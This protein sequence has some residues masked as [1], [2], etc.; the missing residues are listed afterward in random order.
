MTAVRR[1][2]PPEA[3]AWLGDLVD[4]GLIEKVSRLGWGFRNESWKLV[5]SD[6]RRLAVTRHA[7]PEAAAAAAT[8]SSLVRQRVGA[9]GIPTPSVVDLATAPVESLLITEFIEGT[10]GAELLAVNGGSAIV[11]SVLGGTWRR[12]HDVDTA[13]LPLDATWAVG[14][15]LVAASVAR[16]RR[17]GPLLAGSERRQL[18]AAID[19]AGGWLSGRRA[20]FAHGDLA[21]VNVVIRGGTLAALLDLEFVRLA[22]PLLDAAWFDWI[23]AYH[24]PADEPAAWRAFVASSLIDESDAATRGLLGPLPVLRILELLD[25]DWRHDERAM[26]WVQM[27]RACLARVARRPSTIESTAKR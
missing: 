15:T 19:A 21:P 23:V 9:V 27:L 13:G 17:A 20:G 2:L 4:P 5:L 16:A 26:H 12:L 22:D 8:L 11:G 14:D 7:D 10:P 18:A 3:P 24:H 25:Q 6:G 1:S